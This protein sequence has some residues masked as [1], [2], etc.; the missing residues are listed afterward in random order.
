MKKNEGFTIFE[1][2]IVIV[3]IAILAAAILA[4][5]NPVEQFKRANDEGRKINGHELLR[6]IGR[7]QATTGKN[8]EIFPTTPNYDCEAIVTREPINDLT[9]LKF[10]LSSWFAARINEW[11][12]RLFVGLLPSSGLAKICYKVESAAFITKAMQN[13]CRAN[14]QF[15]MC[16][17]E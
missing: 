15:Y 16:V 17:P 6:S 14:S 8:P 2:L 3:L 9:D 1:L 5:I 7:Y 13:G 10:E 4:A 11:D 12:K